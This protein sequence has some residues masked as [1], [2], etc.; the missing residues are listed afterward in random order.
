MSKINITGN[1][2]PHIVMSYLLDKLLHLESVSPGNEEFAEIMR[3]LKGKGML[4]LI[5]NYY[6]DMDTEYRVKYKL[7]KSAFK[8]DASKNYLIN[9]VPDAFGPP[10]AEQPGLIKRIVRKAIQVLKSSNEFDDKDLK[11]L[12][13]YLSEEDDNG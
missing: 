6:L 1:T 5:R 7:I 9:I 11:L 2:F 4:P 10:P 13:E 12:R 3:K 8:E